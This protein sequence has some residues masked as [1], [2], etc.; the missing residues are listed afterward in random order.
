MKSLLTEEGMS[1]SLG[2]MS[3]TME[4]PFFRPAL[5]SK[6]VAGVLEFKLG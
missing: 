5:G 6:S 1:R 4:S 2:F 3:S